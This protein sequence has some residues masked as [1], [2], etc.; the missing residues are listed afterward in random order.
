[1]REF[2]GLGELKLKGREGKGERRA[3]HHM[4][5]NRTEINEESRVETLNLPTYLPTWLAGWGT[6]TKASTLSS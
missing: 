2:G 1:M 5:V 3:S 6:Q 4:T